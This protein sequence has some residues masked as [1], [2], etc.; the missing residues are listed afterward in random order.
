VRLAVI[1][2][3]TITYFSFFN[4]LISNTI[5]VISFAILSIVYGV[6]INLTL[7]YENLSNKLA[8]LFTYGIDLI[9]IL[10][11]MY[12]TGGWQ[13]PFWMLLLISAVGFALRFKIL[14]TFILCEIYTLAFF[15]VGLF[16]DG[17][18][19]KEFPLAEFVVKG[20]FL[21]LTAI[22]AGVKKMDNDISS[23]ANRNQSAE[24]KQIRE[25]LSVLQERID[26]AASQMPFVVIIVN[27]DRNITY[28]SQ[29][30]IERNIRSKS[31]YLNKSVFDFI[32]P[33][34]HQEYAAALDTVSQQLKSVE[35][36]VYTELSDLSRP[37]YFKSV[38][39][40]C[41]IDGKIDS[42][43]VVIEDVT[44]K[45]L[46]AISTVV[47]HAESSQ[48]EDQVKLAYAQGLV[49]QSEDNEVLYTYAEYIR[50]CQIFE[51]EMRVTARSI[52]P[53]QRI[54][55]LK[56]LGVAVH[57]VIPENVLAYCKPKS[58]I[59]L[60]NT[61]LNCMEKVHSLGIRC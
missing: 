58:S 41:I 57:C 3:C 31:L 26:I 46:N 6:Y 1:V 52:I 25:K 38:I 27:L 33:N 8:T 11:W 29:A 42:F 47:K 54:E 13:S 5:L 56:E 23:K 20:G 59:F 61:I 50:Y 40:P 35:I 18:S 9:L 60:F 45:K 44:D 55:R 30:R 22:L 39:S 19:M 37:S 15:A 24:V 17:L 2:F 51:D 10:T 21:C 32:H 48:L 53:I 14:H 7:P 43:V 12:L 28:F 49:L 16:Y 36:E 34:H 4:A